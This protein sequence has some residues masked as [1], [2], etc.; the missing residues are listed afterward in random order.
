M[1][2]D[3]PTRTA[4]AATIPPLPA[5][6][7]VVGLG[8]V[9][10]PVALTCAEAGYRVI[11]VD[12]DPDRVRA[13]R[14]ADG[15]DASPAAAAAR[16]GALVISEDASTLGEAE[17]VFICVPTPLEEGEARHEAVRACAAAFARHGRPDALVI[18]ESTVRPGFV[19]ALQPLLGHGG[20]VAL[21]YAPERMDPQRGQ[22][23]MRLRDIARLV[24]GLTPQAE[25]RATA[26]LRSLGVAVSPVSLR[27][28]EYAKLLE[29]AYRLL[30]VAFIDQF[31]ALCRAD[32]VDPRA[33][34]AAAATKPFGFQPFWPGVGA[35]GHCVA[36]DPV[37]LAHRGRAQGEP[38]TLLEGAL[39]ANARRP[40]AVAAAVAAATAP[41]D[42]L[43]VVGL[44]YKA[45][46]AD[47]RESAAL[48]A[49]RALGGMNRQVLAYDPLVPPPPDLA[50]VTLAEGLREAVAVVLLVPQPEPILAALEA[51]GLPLFDATG[52]L[53]EA[54]RV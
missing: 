18:L 17:A 19:E 12:S 53:P 32:S 50:A 43:L 22:E 15:P 47:T 33:V 40:R 1:P 2:T 35:G 27:V 4:P 5:V 30:N 24:A 29:N 44:T 13:L 14:E 10:L 25:A 37:F 23:G 31:A 20:Q 36:V 6:V 49:A 11:G 45:G 8:Y 21:A 38:L 3:P 7:A 41:R 9:G 48:A 26:L 51:S 54:V 52:V 39:E 16:A 46:V 42:P 34:I 28:A